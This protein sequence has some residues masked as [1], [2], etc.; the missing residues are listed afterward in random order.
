MTNV[1]LVNSHLIYQNI[2]LSAYFVLEELEEELSLLSNAGNL[3]EDV[4]LK[5]TTIW[6]QYAK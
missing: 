2:I 4:K 3:N 5:L 1:I 6:L